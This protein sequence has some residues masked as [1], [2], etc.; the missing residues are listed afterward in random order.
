M[1]K[2]VDKKDFGHF[3]QIDNLTLRDE[4][5]SL[6]AKGLLCYMLSNVDTW[7]F[8]EK[9]LRKQAKVGEDKLK[10]ILKELTTQGYL[11]RTQGR[12]EHGRFIY[13]YI[14]YERSKYFSSLFK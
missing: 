1:I 12:K 8:T 10:K 7:V 6:E 2:R 11:D 14:I 13:D 3:T 5:L 9:E 4:N